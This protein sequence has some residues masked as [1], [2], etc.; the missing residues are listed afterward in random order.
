ML[1]V[2][3]RSV[4]VGFENNYPK[5]IGYCYNFIFS[6]GTR[7]YQ[8]DRNIPYYNHFIPKDAVNR[9]RQVTI[10]YVD[11]IRGF[12]FSDKDGALIYKIGD[13]CSSWTG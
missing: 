7:S 4:L 10:Y 8:H 9:I 3:K 11:C 13:V 5:G 12:S 1:A 6:N 2:G